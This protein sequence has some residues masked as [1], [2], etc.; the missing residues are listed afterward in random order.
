MHSMHNRKTLKITMY[1]NAAMHTCEDA[2][3]RYTKEDN[4][5]K[6]LIQGTYEAGD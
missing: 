1:L 4:Q 2:T 6:W 5:G 3:L